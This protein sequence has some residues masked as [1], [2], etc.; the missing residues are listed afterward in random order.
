MDVAAIGKKTRPLGCGARG[1]ARAPLRRG[2]AD[3]RRGGRAAL[4]MRRLAGEVG[5]SP[6]VA[7]PAF[8]GQA[9]ADRRRARAAFNRLAEVVDVVAGDGRHRA[10]DI[11]EAYGITLRPPNS[12]RLQA[13]VRPRP[14]RRGRLS[15]SSHPAASAQAREAM[16]GY[17]REL[18]DAGVLAGDPVALG[19]VFW[20]AI[21]GLVVLDLAGRLPGG[22]AQLRDPARHRAQR[23]DARAASLARQRRPSPLDR[24]AKQPQTTAADILPPR[25]RGDHEVAEGVRRRFD[26]GDWPTRLRVRRAA[27]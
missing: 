13:D 19:Y 27:T 20:A 8:R 11:G 6:M 12:G 14:A 22:R 16:S 9:G 26:L 23:P 2:G 17:V 5:C 18:V 7:L 4:S 3:L 15:K 24:T 21:H 25:G 10:A 1:G